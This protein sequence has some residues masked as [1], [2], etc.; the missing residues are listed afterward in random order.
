MSYI[1]REGESTGVQEIMCTSHSSLHSVN[2]CH[3]HTPMRIVGQRWDLCFFF[4]LVL[5]YF[6]Q[7][8]LIHI[9]VLYPMNVGIFCYLMKGLKEN[10]VFT[11][12][13]VWVSVSM[14]AY[15]F[16]IL[17]AHCF[18][19]FFPLLYWIPPRNEIKKQNNKTRFLRE[20]LP[21]RH[22]HWCICIRTEGCVS[23]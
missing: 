4:F 10:V 11:V 9:N 8:W 12:L 18:F 23:G 22:M 1:V 6:T 13:I 5:F 20:F 14:A 21:S 17:P 16:V 19:F 2:R 15:G 3:T 7:K